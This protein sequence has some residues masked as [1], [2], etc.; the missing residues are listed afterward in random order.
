MAH[1]YTRV[2]VHMV[3][4][5][6]ERRPLIVPEL[7]ADLHAY[8]AG[9]SNNLGCHVYAL[10]GVA[11]HCHLV[12]DL[13]RTVALAEFANKVKSGST[14]WVRRERGRRNFGW[15][16]GYGAF[17]VSQQNLER[18]VRYVESQE[19]HHQKR[20]FQEELEAFME[21]HGMAADSEFIEGVYRRPDNN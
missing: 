17:S 16:R 2:L 1:T 21:Q 13:S 12:F 8:M 3:F 18:A 19:P 6:R 10:G 15:Q 7:Q 9:I 20:S 11:D 14:K 5:T 4:A